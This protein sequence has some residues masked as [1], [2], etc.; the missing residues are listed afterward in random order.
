MGRQEIAIMALHECTERA[1]PRRRPDFDQR[2]IPS[3]RHGRVQTVH[4]WD[5]PTL[6]PSYAYRR[7]ELRCTGLPSKLAE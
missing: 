6:V 3:L 5:G 2:R 7:P 4:F 1:Y